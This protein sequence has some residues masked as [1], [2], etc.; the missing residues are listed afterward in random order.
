M[1]PTC[2]QKQQNTKKK[3]TKK[4]ELDFLLRLIKFV[5]PNSQLSILQALS[6]LNPNAQRAIDGVNARGVWGGWV[7]RRKGGRV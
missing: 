3:K 7:G 4:R 6:S 5:L 1:E 2:T